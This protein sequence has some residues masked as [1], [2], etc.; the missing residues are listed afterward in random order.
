MAD[1]AGLLQQEGVR[2]L[3]LTGAGGTGKT[4][5]ALQAAAEV[6]DDYPDGVW[7]VPLASIRDPEL[8]RAQAARA[9]DS[10][11]GLAEHIPTG[12][13]LCCSTTSST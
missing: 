9:V 12:R 3:T 5:L 13:C 6:S 4:R 2:L 11:D 1:V 7:W 8:V 10:R